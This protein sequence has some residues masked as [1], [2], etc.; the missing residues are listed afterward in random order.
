LPRR[1]SGRDV[2]QAAT[3]SRPRRSPGRDVLQAATFVSRPR[4]SPG[5]DDLPKQRR[6]PSPETIWTWRRSRDHLDFLFIYIVARTLLKTTAWST[7]RHQPPRRSLQAATFAIASS[8]QAAT[9]FRPRRSSPGSDV[10]QAATF[11]RPRRSSPGSDVHQEPPYSAGGAAAIAATFSRPRRSS[12]R[13]VRLQAAT[14]TRPRRSAQTATVTVARDLAAVQRPSGLFVYIY[15]R[16]FVIKNHCLVYA[17]PR[18]SLLRPWD[19]NYL[20]KLLSHPAQHL[21]LV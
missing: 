8:L 17:S 12:G 7:L 15:S 16:T 6:S 18:F 13:D 2:L 20:P 3:F 11:F 10:H 4:R 21:H 19:R 5:R 14:F 9:F 1:S